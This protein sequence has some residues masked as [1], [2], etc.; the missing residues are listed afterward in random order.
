MQMEHVCTNHA[1]VCCAFLKI[2]GSYILAA[3]CLFFNGVF[4]FIGRVVTT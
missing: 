3:N 1:F 4:C 2:F